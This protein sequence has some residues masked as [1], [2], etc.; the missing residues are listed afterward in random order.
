MIGQMPISQVLTG[1][2]G[3]SQPRGESPGNSYFS[4]KAGAAPARTVAGVQR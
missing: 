2:S 3:E 1:P 4:R